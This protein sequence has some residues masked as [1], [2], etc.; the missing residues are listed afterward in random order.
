M[1]DVLKMEMMLPRV[2]LTAK[3]VGLPEISLVK[4]SNE[5]SET[6]VPTAKQTKKPNSRC[7]KVI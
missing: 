5:L 6:T 2:Y 7:F 4:E 1:N 3:G